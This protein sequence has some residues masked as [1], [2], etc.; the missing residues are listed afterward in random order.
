MN[1]HSDNDPIDALL[2]EEPGYIEDDG[3]TA[4]VVAALPARRSLAWLRPMLILGATVLGLALTVWWVAGEGLAVPGPAAPGFSSL[5]VSVVGI[6][7][8]ASIVWGAVAALR[9]EQ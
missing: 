7:L 8:I 9:W 5:A 6:S 3:F 1:E 4:R 2:R